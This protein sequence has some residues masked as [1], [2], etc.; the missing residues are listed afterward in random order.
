MKISDDA[1][2]VGDVM[3][4]ALYQNLK[5]GKVNESTDY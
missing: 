4:L 2:V 1:F 3:Y 5:H